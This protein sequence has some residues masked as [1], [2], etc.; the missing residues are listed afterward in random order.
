MIANTFFRSGMIETWG[1]GIRKINEA[2]RHFGKPAPVFEV[3]PNELKVT[4]YSDA[5]ITA[6][7][8][9]NETQ[10]RILALMAQTPRITVKAL[11]EEIGIADRN[12]KSNI[13][14]LKKAGLVERV[15]AA[16][17]G[18]WVVKEER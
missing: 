15:G 17:N 6:N 2:C 11:A 18:Q 4:F 3:K 13:S 8:T 14:V 9:L 12:V 7:I 10:R 5:N 16:K 1:R